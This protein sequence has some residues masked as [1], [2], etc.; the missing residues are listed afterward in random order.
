MHTILD[1][2]TSAE[3]L[4]LHKALSERVSAA[5]KVVPVGD[6]TVSVRIEGEPIELLLIVSEKTKDSLLAPPYKEIA[7]H[8]MGKVNQATID[9]LV[10]DATDTKWEPS[11]DAAVV[12]AFSDI[13]TGRD[14]WRKGSR[15]MSVTVVEDS[16]EGRENG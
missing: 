6:H 11:T 4:A 14:Q 12:N 15:K 3:V 16:S 2:L 9:A 13:R 7:T 8:L 10:T 1:K 5:R